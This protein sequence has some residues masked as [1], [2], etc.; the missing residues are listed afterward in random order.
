MRRGVAWAGS[1]AVDD[2]SWWT[3]G[4]RAALW[5]GPAGW[6]RSPG[7]GWG[8]NSRPGRAASVRGVRQGSATRALFV[9]GCLSFRAK[10]KIQLARLSP[11]ALYTP[12]LFPPPPSL[13]L[14]PLALS[15]TPPHRAWRASKSLCAQIANLFSSL[16]LSP[17]ERRGLAP[18]TCAHRQLRGSSLHGLLPRGRWARVW[19]PSAQVLESP[20]QARHLL[21][22]A[23]AGATAT[24]R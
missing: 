11:D 6:R 14:S 5:W 19:T 7:E 9:L 23:S 20:V 13:C 18:D 15:R 10:I 16:C 2:L 12:R 1:F 22:R 17:I 3:L 4:M 24:P 8:G 21:L